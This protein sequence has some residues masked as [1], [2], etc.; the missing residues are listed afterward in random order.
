VRL[1]EA[2]V[3]RDTR[4]LP[5]RSAG[6]PGGVTVLM[7]VYRND[8]PD[9][10]AAALA[11]V[12]E[13]ECLPD[14]V[15]LVVDGPVSA[16]IE[17]VIQDFS[18][19]QALCV[20]RLPENVGLARALNAGLE[21]IT[22]S[23]VAR[24][25]ADDINEPW[26]LRLQAQAA[27]SNP[28]IALIGGH[29]LEVDGR[30]RP[31]AQRKVPGTQAEIARFMR[32][33]SP[34][35]HMTVAFRRDA[36]AKVG[37]YPDIYLREDYALWASLLASGIQCVNLD[38]VLVRASAGTGLYRRRG[39]MRYAKGELQL[40]AHLVRCGIKS[41]ARGLVDGLVRSAVFLLPAALRGWLYKNLLRDRSGA[42]RV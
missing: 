22:T 25:D 28:A 39:G 37:G 26:R 38:A 13:G 17:L 11:S 31:V 6:F 33:R 35:N 29:V 14:A 2:I 1:A 7:S 18:Q 20:L 36:V 10:F 23:W 30:S 8:S 27:A 3:E 4:S 12:F 34:F 41:P 24:A 15:Q 5:V 42:V 19:R 40:Q 9:L 21:R 32:W 16:G